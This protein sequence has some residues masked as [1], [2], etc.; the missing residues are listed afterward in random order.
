MSISG[1]ASLLQV[2]IDA[3][4]AAKNSIGFGLHKMIRS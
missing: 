4:L 1:S 2:E 3:E